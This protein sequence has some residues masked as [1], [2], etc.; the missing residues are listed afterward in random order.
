[1]EGKNNTRFEIRTD[2][3]VEKKED[4]KKE[5]REL[6]GVSLKEWYEKET[7]IKLTR[8]EILNRAGEQAMGKAKGTYM[9][10]EAG[11]MAKKDQDYHRQVSRE[12]AKQLKTL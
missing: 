7:E 12:L 5:A 6:S 1:M 8:V 10:L 3:A 11:Q 9:T 4:F 2:L